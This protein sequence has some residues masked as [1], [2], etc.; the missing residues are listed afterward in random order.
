MKTDVC[1]NTRCQH[2]RRVHGINGCTYT[3]KNMQSCDCTVAYMQK[4][5]FREGTPK[6]D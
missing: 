6:N 2:E 4:Q 3:R 1:G 5:Y